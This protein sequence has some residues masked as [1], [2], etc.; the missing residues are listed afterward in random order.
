MKKNED[1]KIKK[2]KKI[3]EWVL[4]MKY[5]EEGANEKRE[6]EV[7]QRK[8]NKN[9]YLTILWNVS[10]KSVNKER[11]NKGKV[12]I[13]GDERKRASKKKKKEMSKWERKKEHNRKIR[14]KGRE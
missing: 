12:K 10:H 5:C 4:V 8:N 9:T 11:E 7:N 2:V 1:D 14:K 3:D 6:H 13:L